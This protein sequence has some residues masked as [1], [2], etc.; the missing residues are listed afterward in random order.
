MIRERHAPTAV[1]SFAVVANGFAEGPAQALRD[2]LVSCEADV[3]TILHPLTPEQGTR[4]LVTV[5]S[6]GRLTRS[7]KIAIPVRPPLSFAVDPFV[8]LR[9]PRVDAWFG[10]NPLACAR[11]LFARRAGRARAVALWSVDFVPDRFGTGSPL[12]RLYDRLDRLDC[13]RADARIELSESAR[14]ARNRRHGLAGAAAHAHVV[15]MGAWLERV[16]TTTRDSIRARRVVFLG[17]LVP[18]MGVETLLDALAELRGRGEAIEAD[19]I[20]TGPL[21]ESLRYRAGALGLGPAVRFH[22]F[23]PDHREVER[24]LALGSLAA[25][26]YAEDGDTFTRFA[27]PGKLKAYLAAGLPIVLTDV[28]PNAGELAREAGAEIV[29]AGSSALART[30]SRVLAA[31]EEWRERRLAALAYARR[32]DWAVLLPSLLRDLGLDVAPAPRA[33][34]AT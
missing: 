11:G 32:F 21:E 18:R 4:H 5:H 9:V 34:P 31:P 20:G 29:G 10:F 14:D 27:D 7:G 30:I 25:A 3:V 6:G 16:P 26:P 8:P 15:P 1:R 19:V 12:T 2:Y 22:G 23:V 13:T 28:P 17:H 24:L 33:K